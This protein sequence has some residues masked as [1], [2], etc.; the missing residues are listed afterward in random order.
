MVKK[1][2]KT[3]GSTPMAEAAP[4]GAGLLDSQFGQLVKESAQ[5]IWS[6]GL[7]AFAKAQNNSGK[8]F[9][10]LAEEGARI[11]KKTQASAEERLGA[12]ASRMSDM[13]GEVGTRAGQHWDKL[14][15][16]FEDRV[17]RALHR[18]GVP[19]AKDLEALHQRLEALTQALQAQGGEAPAATAKPVK[20]VKPVKA[21]KPGKPAK[22]SKSSK[23]G[24][25]KAGTASAAQP[26]T[27]TGTRRATGTAATKAATSSAAA[28]K[29]T[30]ATR[31]K[32]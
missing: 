9:D 20:P 11:Q 13:A 21:V 6:A 19:T 27:K 18:L 17:A 8:A 31:T 28:K 26:S 15:S 1:V 23:N 2:K 4:A 29:T 16:I 10:T 3:A 24:L 7:A 14:E 32:R 25:A 30:A 12:V 5:Q 22:A